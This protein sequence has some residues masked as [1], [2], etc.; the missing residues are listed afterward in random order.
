M[1]A[2][3]LSFNTKSTGTNVVNAQ[4]NKEGRDISHIVPRD[5]APAYND[6]DTDSSFLNLNYPFAS[7][8]IAHP[9]LSTPMGAPTP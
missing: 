8:C 6:E 5:I 7:W 2:C 3:R 9:S 4:A 1:T